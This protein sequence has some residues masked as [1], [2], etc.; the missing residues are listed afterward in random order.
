MDINIDPPR[1]GYDRTRQGDSYGDICYRAILSGDCPLTHDYRHQPITR[2]EEMQ[3]EWIKSLKREPH[4]HDT[5]DNSTLL[6][7][8]CRDLG[9]NLHHVSEHVFGKGMIAVYFGHATPLTVTRSV[10]A[11]IEEI[12]T[13]KGKYPEVAMWVKVSD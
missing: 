13:L 4:E 5:I 10:A 6:S 2:D 9:I 3:L 11:A 8:V 12:T 7:R 1:H